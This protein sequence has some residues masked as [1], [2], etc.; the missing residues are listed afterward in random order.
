MNSTFFVALIACAVC[1]I[2]ALFVG[3]D[4]ALAAARQARKRG[5]QGK[6]SVSQMATP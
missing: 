5:E 3:R 1:A 6:E 4:P 2:A